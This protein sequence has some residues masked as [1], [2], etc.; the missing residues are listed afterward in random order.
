MGFNEVL[1]MKIVT[2]VHVHLNRIGSTRGGVGSHKRMT[3]YAEA[4]DAEIE[5]LRDL[6]ISIAEQNGEAPRSLNDLRHERQSGYPPRLR[7]SIF[8]RL[9]LH[10]ASPIHIAKPSQRS[11][12]TTGSSS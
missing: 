3:T 2:V 4:S 12:L 7:S 11:R 1:G 8:M 9:A 6:L 5:T 10:S